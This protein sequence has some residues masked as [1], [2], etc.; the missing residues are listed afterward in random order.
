MAYDKIII[1]SKVKCS[2]YKIQNMSSHNFVSMFPGSE[3]DGKNESR[4]FYIIYFIGMITFSKRTFS[5]KK[6]CTVEESQS[7]MREGSLFTGDEWAGEV[8]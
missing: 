4:F 5:E 6:S 1:G 7:S 2:P 8:T 3:V